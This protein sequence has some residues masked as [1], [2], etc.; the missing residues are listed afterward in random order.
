MSLLDVILIQLDR[1]Q[2]LCYGDR[3][4][5][6]EDDLHFLTVASPQLDMLVLA[7]IALQWCNLGVAS[8]SLL[9]LF[10]NNACPDLLDILRIHETADTIGKDRIALR[11]HAFDK[12]ISVIQLNPIAKML[13]DDRNAEVSMLVKKVAGL[14]RL[15]ESE[16]V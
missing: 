10:P 6:N 4:I 13:L 11:V 5:I 2:A 1:A 8:N 14:C 15:N 7:E 12:Q 9:S 3:I 16:D